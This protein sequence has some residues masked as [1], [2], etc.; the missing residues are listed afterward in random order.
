MANAVFFNVFKLDYILKVGLFHY[1][2][3]FFNGFGSSLGE[4]NDYKCRTLAFLVKDV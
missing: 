4:S 2:F 1:L 3:F